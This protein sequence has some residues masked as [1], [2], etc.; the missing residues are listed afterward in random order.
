MNTLDKF[1]YAALNQLR[2]RWV[3]RVGTEVIAVIV[4]VYETEHGPSVKLQNTANGSTL[5]FEALFKWELTDWPPAWEPDGT[6]VEVV[7]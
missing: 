5:R 2:G 1:D 7:A 6:P 4:A 3:R